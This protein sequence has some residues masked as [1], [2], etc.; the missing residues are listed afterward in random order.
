MSDDNLPEVAGVGPAGTLA[1]FERACRVCIR[2]EQAKPN[3]DN[4]LIAVLC[5]AVRLKRE[6]VLV[7]HG[8]LRSLSTFPDGL[9]L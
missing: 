7:V 4:H 6:Y 8:T 9:K 3:P 5:D 2:D 1:D